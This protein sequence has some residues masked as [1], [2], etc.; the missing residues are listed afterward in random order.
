MKNIVATLDAVEYIFKNVHENEM[1]VSHEQNFKN[2]NSWML[3]NIKSGN[4]IIENELDLTVTVHDNCYSKALGSTYWNDP[5]EILEQC[6]C[7]I[8]E[9]KHIKQDSLCC[10][11]GAGASWVKNMSIPFDIISEGVKKFKE[12]EDTGAKALVTYCTGC[13]YLLWAT[14]ELIRSKIDVFHLIEITRMAMGEKLNYP[15]DHVS[16][17]WDIIAIISYSLIQ[18]MIRKKFYINNITYD[19]S[20]STFKP[21]KHLLLK[22]I[23]FMF[24]M[25]PFRLL[26]AKMFQIMMPLMKTR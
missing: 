15:I 23:R 1:N 11:F 4:L 18:S 8:I 20:K 10:G 12:A 14:K 25:A 9:M 6:G 16:R 3:E 7:T 17:A 2:L 22:L 21:S 13:Y 5:R 26:Y 19:A 24:R